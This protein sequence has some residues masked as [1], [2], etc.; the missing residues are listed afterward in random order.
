MPSKHCMLMTPRHRS[1]DQT[2]ALAR[3]PQ[4]GDEKQRG[5]GGGDRLDVVF[6]VTSE[7]EDEVMVEDASQ[8]HEE[9]EQDDAFPKYVARG[10]GKEGKRVQ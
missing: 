7:Q 10:A 6:K 1:D 9:Q 5:D 3:A 4:S 2:S 8:G